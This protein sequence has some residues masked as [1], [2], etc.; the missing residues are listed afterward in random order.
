MHNSNITYA[1]ALGII[2]MVWGHSG[3]FSY[4]RDFIYMFHMPLFFFCAGYCFKESY[5]HTPIKFVWRRVKGLWWPYVKW[6]ALFL[7]L[8]NLFFTVGFYDTTSNH[9]FNKEELLQH[10][11]SIIT[12]QWQ[13]QLQPF[14]FLKALLFGSLIAYSILIVAH[15]LNKTIG[16]ICVKCGRKPCNCV[17]AFKLMGGAIL[18]ALMMRSFHFNNT[19]IDFLFSPRQFLAALLFLTGHIFAY[20]NVRKFGLP[21]IAIVSVS[22][23]IG[24]RYWL[25]ETAPNFY[26]NRILLQYTITAILGT[27]MIYSLPWQ[28]M[29]QRMT[30]VMQYI[31]THTLTILTWHFLCFKLVSIAIIAIYGLPHEKLSDFPIISEYASKGWWVAYLLVGTTIPLL[32]AKMT[33]YI[34]SWY[35][36]GRRC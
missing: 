2:L 34:K 32:M 23:F 3:T 33:E 13:E 1:K 35:S 14:W 30:K 29:G 7:L 20:L 5:Y 18:T 10:A 27:W 11:T 22:V 9:L 4:I 8:H 15:I 28:L 12:T 31:G 21:Y 36:E 24:S 17:L 16:A 19:S 6:S 26:D 25:M